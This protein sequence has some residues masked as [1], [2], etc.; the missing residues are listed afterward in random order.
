MGVN[1]FVDPE[2]SLIYI[3]LLVMT[4]NLQTTR[5]VYVVMGDKE[6]SAQMAN[7]VFPEAYQII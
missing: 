3:G 4:T 5:L 7:I 1:D 2:V 6:N